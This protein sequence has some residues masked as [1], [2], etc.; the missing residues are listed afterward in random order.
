M[1]TAPQAEAQGTRDILL[2]HGDN[3]KVSMKSDSNILFHTGGGHIYWRVTGPTAITMRKAIDRDNDGEVSLWEGRTYTSAVDNWLTEL[4]MNYH[5]SKMLRFD[6]IDSKIE[7]DTSGLLTSVNSSL[8][9]EISFLFDAAPAEESEPYELS[10]DVFIRA[11]FEALSD[12]YNQNNIDAPFYHHYKYVG[13]VE[14]EHYNACV[15]LHDFKLPTVHEGSMSHYVLP[16]V[17]YY[18]Y[19]VSYRVADKEE[20]WANF[21]TFDPIFNTLTLFVIYLVIWLIGITI[22]KWCAN[23]YNKKPV[24]GLRLGLS[25]L[26]L[27]AFFLF[28]FDMPFFYVLGGSVM[29]LVLGAVLGVVV[30]GKTNLAKDLDA[31]VKKPK[32]EPKEKEYPRVTG[33]KVKVHGP[34]PA[35]P[36]PV[37]LAPAPVTK[38]EPAPPA[39]PEEKVPEYDDFD[40]HEVFYIYKDGRVITHCSAV[41]CETVAEKDLVGSML[42]AIQGFVTDSFRKEGQLDGFDFG[43]NKIAVKTGNHGHLVC[44]I[45]GKEPSF[46]RERMAE[47]TQK[48]EGM[49]A[50]VIEDWDGNPAMFKGI[51]D[52]I[53]PLFALKKGLKIKA[54]PEVVKVKSAVEFYEGFLRLKVGILNERKTTITDATFRLQFDKTVMRLNHIDPAYPLDGSAVELGVISPGEKKSIAFYLDPLICQVSNVDGSATY[55][56]Y[57][58]KFQTA[59]MKR[60]PAEI[61]CPIFFTPTT[62]NVA[63]LRRLKDDLPYKDGKIFELPA[64]AVLKKIFQLAKESITAYNVKPVKEFVTPDPFQAEAWL[65]GKTA[66]TQ[67]EM[68]I[69]ILVHHEMRTVQVWVASNN[70]ATQAGLLAEVGHVLGQKIQETMQLPDILLPSTDKALKLKVEETEAMLD[71]FEQNDQNDQPG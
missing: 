37:Q 39:P 68:I 38:E 58:G 43:N 63:M 62:I 28:F 32:F 34:A 53:Q 40:I 61:I 49:Y 42:V 60:R 48:L 46:L 56:D 51:N 8:P 66:E 9:L 69:K 3:S 33:E 1:L 6:L 50:G 71:S 16:L 13:Q 45:A 27:L 52:M 11:L 41:G 7:T 22:P 59:V 70:L 55:R 64:D 31:A 19:K 23:H 35:G 36:A 17:D 65:Y 44:V 47:V 4:H 18:E 24:L 25:L 67:E 10:D 57:K 29:L 2:G 12:V 14:M 26:A 54:R 5:G 30:Y 20:D 21:S 15:G